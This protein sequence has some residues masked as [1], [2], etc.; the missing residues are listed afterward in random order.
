[1]IKPKTNKARSRW[2]GR[3]IFRLEWL[4][5]TLLKVV[6]EGA[7]GGAGGR[8]MSQAEGTAS[9]EE[10]EVDMCM[11]RGNPCGWSSE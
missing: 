3:L 9:C 4:G 5:K 7:I 2:R 11:V 10:P 8:I 1:M 6:R